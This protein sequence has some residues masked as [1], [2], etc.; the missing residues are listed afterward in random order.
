MS[1]GGIVVAALSSAMVTICSGVII[2]CKIV[3]IALSSLMVGIVGVSV[4]IGGVCSFVKA[5]SCF[6]GGRRDAACRR[7]AA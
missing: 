6:T 3:V 7:I 5:G 2:V 4:V 1:C